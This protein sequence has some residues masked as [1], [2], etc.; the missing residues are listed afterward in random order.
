MTR[1]CTFYRYSP[2][3]R[4]QIGRYALEHGVPAATKKFSRKLDVELSETTVIR[5]GKATTTDW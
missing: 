3:E 4:A 2:K 1:C 5:R